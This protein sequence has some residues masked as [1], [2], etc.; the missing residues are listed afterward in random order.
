MVEIGF[1]RIVLAT[2]VDHRGVGIVKV[3]RGGVAPVNRNRKLG[4]ENAAGKKVVFVRTAGVG[5]DLLHN[6]GLF[7]F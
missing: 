3:F 5:D 6:G 2:D 7:H 1:S 4:D